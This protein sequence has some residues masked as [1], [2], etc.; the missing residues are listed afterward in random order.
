MESLAVVEHT[1]RRIDHGV[2]AAHQLIR[3]KNR[4]PLFV[5]I[6]EA[7]EL[8][9]GDLESVEV[10]VVLTDDGKNLED[11]PTERLESVQKVVHVFLP[12]SARDDGVELQA[13][14]GV[15]ADP[16]AEA[17]VVGG[18]K[19]RDL[20]ANAGC[21]AATDLD[22]SLG[23]GAVDGKSEL[24]DDFEEFARTGVGSGL[25]D[26]HQKRTV[27]D[28]A[29]LHSEVLGEFEQLVDV[30]A[31]H[32]LA[33]SEGDLV[34]H[35]GRSDGANDLGGLGRFETTGVHSFALLVFVGGVAKLAFE[36]ATF[37]AHVVHGEFGENSGADVA[38]GH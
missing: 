21:K 7:L 17:E 5:A 38:G 31:H 20:A 2:T 9:V 34:E 1:S 29:G 15:L 14:V 19:W 27:G 28:E 26:A 8:L 11:L 35:V 3:L 32:R 33:A 37:D 10:L 30:R 22:A 23:V 18:R 24:I 25:A 4:V 16:L 13:D 36:V 12:R 6:D